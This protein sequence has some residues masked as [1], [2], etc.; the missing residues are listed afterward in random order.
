MEL[1]AYDIGILRL[2]QESCRSTVEAI[3]EHVGL[4]GPAV[5]RRLKRLRE[6]GVIKQE[7]A[8]L[9]PRQLGVEM[10]FI[11]GVELEREQ[12]DV[13][14]AIRRKLSA[15][16]E[17]QQCYY[18]TGEFDLILIV[19]T[20]DMAA[21]ET[22]THK[23]FFGDNNVRKFSTSVVMSEVKVGLSLPISNQN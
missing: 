1:D 11:V 21:F 10:S 5:H 20:A 12:L 6:G 22:F 15:L 17:V 23:A 18:V 4:S 8:I 13:L 9:D 14:T 7:V 2:M 3:G 19:R 16:P